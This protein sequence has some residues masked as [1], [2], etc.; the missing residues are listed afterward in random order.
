MAQRLWGGLNDGVGS[1]KVEDSAG[2]MEI[3]GRKFW[4]P[5]G[6]SK[7]LWGLGFA[8]AT[9]QFI[10]RATTV[11]TGISDAIGLVANA[12]RISIAPF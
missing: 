4:Q 10:Y 2:S 8:K 5:D 3:F 7:S 1:G 6:V 12:T 9:Q 11:A